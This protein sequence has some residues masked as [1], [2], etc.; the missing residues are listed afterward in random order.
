MTGPGSRDH[1][2]VGCLTWT[3]MADERDG[4]PAHRTVTTWGL[5]AGAVVAALV[6]V[7]GGG[8]SVTA[9]ALGA[10]VVGLV[11][12]VLVAAGI[13]VNLWVFAAISLTCAAFI[14][15][16]EGNEGGMFPVMLMVVWVAHGSGSW[17]LNAT[18]LTASIG[19]LVVATLR[20]GSADETGLVYM[21]A[22]LGISWLSGQLLRRQEGLTRQLREM[23]ELRVRHAAELERTRIARDVHDVVAHS[24]TI[25][26]LHI[27]GARRA[28]R[29]GTD[30]ADDALARAESV[31][32]E[33]LESIRRVMGQLR[34]SVDASSPD[35]GNAGLS[36]LV[37]RYRSGGLEVEYELDVPSGL[38]P[39]SGL[40]LYRVVQESLTN[41]LRHAPRRGVPPR[42]SY[43]P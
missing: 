39:T 12:W 2:R 16:G 43:R 37:D 26:M 15:I 36:G 40:V 3:A 14:V 30:G 32:R 4:V 25:A 41:V 10:A 1:S 27:T 42:R 17:T 6:A 9:V 24:L 18:V 34:D 21:T 11:P 8:D 20:A 22:G 29:A 7:F 38:D 5:C 23:D 35:P 13:N 28:L 31:G 33:S 19:V